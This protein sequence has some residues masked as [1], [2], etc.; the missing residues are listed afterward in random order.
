MKPL[1]RPYE[2]PL[3]E[4]QREQTRQRILDAATEL[5]AAG[6]EREL[7]IAG[8]ARRAGVAVRTVYV[9]YP[10]KDALFHAVAEQID[11]SI[12]LLAYPERADDLPA[13]AADLYRRFGANETLVRAMQTAAGRAVRDRGRERRLP[14]LVR[15]L[16][17]ELE[18]LSG[19]ERRQVLAVLY[20]LHNSPTWLTMRDTFGLSVDEAAQATAWAHALVLQALREE[21]AGLRARTITNPDAEER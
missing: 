7:T 11:R 9:H 2:S 12:G 20:C 18:P 21:P 16:G 6:T 14:T 15:A 10:S 5:L 17:P 1:T 8:V 13:F 3:R 19:T 4:E